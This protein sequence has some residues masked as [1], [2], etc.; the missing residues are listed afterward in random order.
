MVIWRNKYAANTTN[1]NVTQKNEIP[2]HS[3]TCGEDHTITI[4]NDLIYGHA[5]MIMWKKFRRTITFKLG[6][7]QT[8]F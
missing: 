1:F 2:V 3:V 8:K 6:R 4:T 7:N 5:F